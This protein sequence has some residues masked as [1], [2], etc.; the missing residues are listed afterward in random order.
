MVGSSVCVCVGGLYHLSVSC[1]IHF[2][3]KLTEISNFFC[4]FSLSQ[5]ISLESSY[6]LRYLEGNEKSSLSLM[7]LASKT[8]YALPLTCGSP[9]LRCRRWRS[10]VWNVSSYNFPSPDIVPHRH[11]ES[12]L[13]RTI[14]LRA[15]LPNLPTL[16]SGTLQFLSECFQ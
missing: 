11:Q 6:Y 13:L 3:S 2:A 12:C 5:I 7:L 15:S 14:E 10:T 1:L 16:I 9:L 4:P 8:G